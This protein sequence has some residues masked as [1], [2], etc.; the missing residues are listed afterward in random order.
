MREIDLDALNFYLTFRYI[1]EDKTIFSNVRRVLPGSCV[2]YDMN[3][4]SLRET[5]YWEQCLKEYGG[6]GEEEILSDLDMFFEEA[7]RLRTGGETAPARI[8]NRMR[9]GRVLKVNSH[10]FT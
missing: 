10:D 2:S 5:R 4:G 1:P 3:S 8:S 7:V 6:G 9:F